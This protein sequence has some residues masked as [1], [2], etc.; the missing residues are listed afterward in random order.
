MTDEELELAILQRYVEHHDA[1]GTEAQK[2]A[3]E[4][5][6]REVISSIIGQPADE[7]VVRRLHARL[8]PAS[9]PYPAGVL[10]PCSD[11]TLNNGPHRF[12]A[13]AYYEPGKAPAWERIVELENKLP[14]QPL[15]KKEK[16]Q[17]F[18]ILNS[19][20]QATTDF[21]S[22]ASRLGTDVSIGVLFLDIDDFKSLNT[23][24]TESVVD[25]E[26][27][28][29][30]QNLL[31]SACLYRGDAYRHGGEEFLVLLPNHTTEEVKQFAERLRRL[32][33]KE[34]FSVGEST[35]RIT[36]SIGAA[37]WPKHGETLDELIQKA[38]RAEHE[39][40]AKGKNRIE[41][42]DECTP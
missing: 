41:A 38:N 29:P 11:S 30:F 18:G 16:E 32:I 28:I 4:L 5:D 26:I 39:A 25:K 15:I 17:K 33:E 6:M 21:T 1:I 14:A 7:A 24:F 13:R 40:K 35:V 22:Y 23:H 12:H 9:P 42:Y 2:C 10:R 20:G 34:E 27:F 8:A 37:L 36:V 19:L 3:R 31:S